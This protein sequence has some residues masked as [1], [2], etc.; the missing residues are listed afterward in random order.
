MIKRTFV[1]LGVLLFIASPVY[2]QTTADLQAQIVLLMKQLTELQAKKTAQSVSTAPSQS[3][4]SCPALSR[5]LSR[6]MRGEDVRGL[7]N[8]LVA[9]GLLTVD[10]ATGFFG[11]LTEAAVK[12]YQCD[13][14][15][16]CSG[17]PSSTGW[18]A[19]GPRTRSSIMS[20]CSSGAGPTAS[21]T[22]QAASSQGNTPEMGKI[23]ED[24]DD[25]LPYVPRIPQK[26]G[27]IGSSGGTLADIDAAL[28]DTNSGDADDITLE[29]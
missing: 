12:K 13:S 8:F 21:G 18:G 26:S 19:V 15:L 9:N 22:Q 27:L 16:V 14:S 20:S 3:S 2:A 11:G 6:N 25:G 24:Y 29:D 28:A 7:Q 5:V 17:S 1:F 10:S 23:T 4:T